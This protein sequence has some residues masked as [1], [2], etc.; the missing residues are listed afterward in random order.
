MGR[1]KKAAGLKHEATISPAL[2]LFVQQTVTVDVPDLP[3]HLLTFPRRWPFPRGDLYH[4]IVVLNRFD[5]I[6]QQVIEKY[7]LNSGPQTKPFGRLV[8]YDTC[9]SAGIALTPE[10]CQVHL[11]TRGFGPEGDRELIEALLDFSRLLLEKCG[12]RS[13]YSSSD[14]LNDLLNTTSLSLLQTALRLG[15]SLAQRYFSRQRQSNSTHFHQSL[16]ASHYNIELE[17]VQK[18]A[19]PFPKPA[20]SKPPDTSSSVKGKEKVAQTHTSRGDSVTKCNANDLI[21]LTKESSDTSEP[22]EFPAHD[23]EEWASIS[24]PY[25]SPSPD[26]NETTVTEGVGSG[27]HPPATPTPLRRVST[28]PSSRLSRS[29]VTDDSLTTPSTSS[30]TNRPEETNRGVKVLEIPS[31]TI[32]ST[33]IEQVLQAHL[34]ELPND[35]SKYELLQRLRVAYAIATSTTTRCQILAIRVLAVTN[36]AYVYP[37]TIFQQKVLYQDSDVPKRLQLAYQL[38]EFVHLGVAGDITAST[39]NQTFALNCLD[40]LA[41]HKTRSADVCAALTVNVNHGILMFL[42][43]KAVADLAVEEKPDDPPEADDWREALFA[44]LRTLPNAGTRTPETLVAAGLIPLFVDILNLRT[45]KA[46]KIY[47]RVMEFLDTFVHSVRDALATLAGAKG[48]HA[49]SD[50]I[51]FETKTSFDSVSKDRG[52]PAQ[53]KTPSIDYKIP[54]FQQ[55]SLR[56]LFKFV[57]HVMQH[58]S[59]GFERLLRNLIDSPP[60]LTALRLVLENA[61]VYGSHVWSGAVNILSHF[62]HNEPTSYAVIA[63][64]GLSRSLLEAVTAQ[65]MQPDTT[66]TTGATTEDGSINAPTEPQ[67]LFIPGR[68]EPGDHEALKSKITRPSGRKLAEGI[69][70]STEAI[71]CIPQAFGAI[72]L[73]QG[74]LELFRRSDALESFFDIFESPE[75]VK[76]MKNDSNL[77]RVLG[78]SFD[79][80]VRHHPA[81][82][83]AVMSSVLLMVARVVQHCKSK[84]WEHGLGAKLWTEEDDG[85]LSIAGGPSSLLGDIGSTFTYTLANQQSPS[86]AEPADTE[87]QS[88]TTTPQD[89]IVKAPP[90]P[91]NWDFKDLD[92]HGLSVPNYMF[93]VVRFLHAFFE[94][95]AICA[96]FIESGGVEYVLDFAT[97]QSLPFDF[98]NTEASQQLAQVIHLM[99]EVKPH[100]V[101]PSLMKRTEDAVD[102]LT[103]FWRQSSST[104]FFTSLT[105]PSKQLE[106]TETPESEDV[107]AKGTYFAKHLVAVHTLTDILREAYTPPIYPTRPSQQTSP[108]VQVNLADKYVALV[109][110]LGAL[111]SACVWEEILLQK[112][113]PE[114]WNEATRVPGYSFGGEEGTEQPS[115]LPADDVS[116][117]GDAAT[118]DAP[119]TTTAGTD[120]ARILPNGEASARNAVAQPF[121]TSEKGPAFRNVKTL[122]YLLSSL[123]SS[124][125]SFFHLLGHGLISKRRMDTYQR[126]KA[127]TVADAI[128]SMILEQINLDAPKKASCIKDQFSYLIVILSSFSQ[129][130]FDTTAERPHSHCLTMILSAFKRL[131]G[132]QALKDLCGL[133]LNEIKTLGPHD[134][135]NGNSRDVPARLASAYGGIKIILNF[136]SEMTSAQYIIDSPQTQAMASAGGDRDRPD[137]FLPAQFLVEFRMEVMPMAQEMWSSSFVEEASSSILK[138]LIDILRSV[139]GG[140]YETGA[141]RRGE[142]L[143]AV[144]AVTPKPFTCHRERLSTL[145]DNGHDENLAREALYRCNNSASASEEYCTSQHG[146]RPPPRNPVPS[147]DLEQATSN[148]T[149]LRDSIFAHLGSSQQPPDNPQVLSATPA[150]IASLLGHLAQPTTSTEDSGTNRPESTTPS[151]QGTQSDDPSNTSGLLAMSIDNILNDQEESPNEERNTLAPAAEGSARPPP[152]SQPAP[153]PKRREVVTVEDLDSERDKIR[154]NLIERCLDVLNV[155][156]DITFELADLIGS[157]TSKLPD[158][159]NFRREMEENFQS[160]G[161]KIAA[162][163]GLLALVLQDK[164]VYDATLEELKENFSNL[165]GF[166]KIPS[167]SSEKPTEESCPWIPQV[168]LILERVLSDDVT[169]SLIRW[170]PPSPD[171]SVGPEEVAELNQPIVPLSDKMALF[172]AMVDILPRVGKDETL[173]LSVSR[174][175]VI[176][177]RERDIAVRLGERRNLQRLFVMIK[178]LASGSDDR[179]QN[180]F[181][182]ILRHIIEDED[183]VRQIMRSEIV[184]GFESRSPRQTDTTGYV[185]QFAHLILRNPTLFV[186]VTNEK[187]KLQRYDSH[188]RPQLLVL[189]SEANNADS[190]RDQSSS[191]HEDNETVDRPEATE[192]NTPPQEGQLTEGKEG[193]DSKEKNKT[194]ELKPPIVE[195]PDGVIHYLLSELLSYR[196]VDDKEPP[197]DSSEKSTTHTESQG[198]VEMLSGPASPTSSTSGTQTTKSP[199]KTDKPQFKADEH[200]IYIYRCFLLQCLTELLS[201]YNRTKVEF[202]NFSRKADPFATTPSKPRSG[203]LNYLLN[204]LVPIGT[205]E[206]GESIFFKKRVNTSNWAMR[207]IVALCSKTGEFG[208]PFRRRTVP[209]DDD[210]PDLLFVRKFVLEHALKSY[211]DANASNEPLDAKYARLLSLADLFDKMLS[212][213]SSADGTTHFPS[214]TRQVAKTMF[215]KNFISAFTASI[216]ELDLNFPPAKRAVKYILRPLNKLTQT[217]VLL[218]ETSSIQ[219]APGQTDEDD[220]SSATSVSD[221]DDER[222]ETPDLFRHSTLGMFEPNHE[223]G[224]TSEEDSEDDEEMYDDEYDEEMDYEEDMPENDGEVVSDEDEE[225]MDGR[226]P[227]EGL[228]GDSGMDIEVL[229]EGDDDEDDDD[230]DEDDDDDDDEDDEDEEGSSAMDDDLIAGEITGD[231]DNDSLQDGDEGEWESEDLSDN[232]E[233][234][235][236]MNQLENELDDFAQ[237]D[238]GSNLQNVLRILGEQNGT[239]LDIQ[240]LELEMGVG[241]ELHDHLMNDEM[242]DDQDE[243]EEVDELEGLDD[244]DEDEDLI[245]TF[246]FEHPDRFMLH[247]TDASMDHNRHQHHGRFRGIPPPPWSMFSGG[248]GSRHGIIPIPGYRTHRNQIQ[249]RGNDDG[250][251]PLLRRNDRPTDVSP[252][253][254]GPPEALSDWVHAID[255]SH[256]GRLL[257]MDSPVTFMNAIMQAL[258]QGGG[259]IGVVSRPDGVHVRLDQGHVFTNRI[260]DLF[261]LSR[262]PA[263]T[264][265]PRDDPYQAVTFVLSTTSTRW[266]E[267]AR[268]LFNDTYLEK[269]QRVVNSLLKVL[270]PPAIE[271]EKVRQKQL[272][273]E[274]RR[275]E[276]ER[277]ERERLE[278]IAKEEAERERKQKEEEE[279]ALRLQQEAE[280]AE[281]AAEESALQAAAQPEGEPMDDVQPTQPS[282]PTQEQ[283]AIPAEPEP[284]TTGPSEPTPRI[285]T[286]I[287][288]RQLDITGMD[289]DPEYLEALPEDIREE[290]IMQQLTEQRSQAAASGEEPSEINPEFL[291]ALPP[292]IR[293]ELLQQEV[294]DRRR[295]ERETA[296]RNAAANGGTAAP[297]DMDPA[298]FIATLDPSL[299]QTVLA[300][301]PEEILASLGPEFVSE[302]RALTGRRLAQFAD[303]GRLDPR[304]RPDTAQ[305]DQGVKKPQRRQ[306]VQ[307]LDKAGVATLLRLMFM[308]LQGN[309]RHHINDILHNVCQNRQ[310]RSEVLSLL[311]L[312][313]QDGSADVSAVER[314][315]AHL[316]LRAKTPAAT[317]R[318]PQVKRTL[319]LPVPGANNDVTPLVVIQQ[320]LG[321]LSF[322]TRFNPHIAW[323]FLTEHDT[324]SSLKIKALRKGKAKEHRAS[325]FALNSLLSLLDRKSIMDS[326]NCMEQLSS[327]LSNITQPLTLLLR[328]DKE[329]QEKEA[330]DKQAEGTEPAAESTRPAQSVEAASEQAEGTRT[331]DEASP[332]TDMTMPDAA[333][334]DQDQGRTEGQDEAA[335]SST[336]EKPESSKPVEEEKQKKLRIPEPPVVPEHNLQLVVRI[337]AARECNG[338]TFRDTLSTINNLSAIP[339]AREVFGK[340]LIAQTQALSNAILIDLDELLPHIKQAETGIDVQGM[341]LSKFSPASS[342]QAKLLRALT[343]LDYLFDPNRLDKEKYSEPESSNKDN[344]LKALYEGATFGPLW[345]KLS[346][347]LHAIRQKENMLNVATILLPLIESLMVVCKNTTLK[348]APLSRHGRE[349]SVSSPPPESGMEGLFFNFTEDHRKI[350]NELVRQN[351]KLM[352][353]TFSLLVKNPKV[354]EFDNKRNYFTRRIHSRGSEI[355]HP[356][357]PLQL[358]VRRDQ[359]FLD[360]F[361]SLYFKTANEMKYGKLNIRFHGE[362]GVDAGGVTREWFQ[363]LARGMFN[364][365]YALFIPVASDRTTFH[366]NRLSGVNQE[367]LMFFKFIGR[368]IGKALYEGRVLDC[369]FSRAVY[370]RILGKAVS[371]KD[372]ETLDLDYYKSLLWMLE[373]DITDILTENFSV[374]SDD[375]G[376]K[377]IIDL[378]E[379]GRNIPVTQENKEEYVQRVVEYRLVGSVKDQLDNFLKGFHD[380]IPADLISIF[381]EQELELLISG[382]PEIDVD[383]WKNNSEY[384]NYSASSPQIQWFWRAVRS[385]DKEER[386]KLLQFVTGTSKVPLN[387][388]KELEGMNG[389]SKFNIHRDYGNKDRLPSSHTCFNQLDLPEYESYETLR[390]RLYTAM[391]AG[392]EYFGFA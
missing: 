341:A 287:R 387:G 254:R 174:I 26:S 187:I 62:I 215:E 179:L 34:G 182:V 338:K 389:F 237:G 18:L 69:I 356:H 226:G 68:A 299:R 159:V 214:S 322:L 353:G 150:D 64:A 108:F 218:S 312:I 355:R 39:L 297:D 383:D 203:I 361:K 210:E 359:V 161:K 366:P 354:L 88:A 177:T 305:R 6:L 123:P 251:N 277:V 35:A 96:S 191:S 369:H 209:N 242:Q 38:A 59:G 97:L 331:A 351:P 323:F 166:I 357:P 43:R 252:G 340:E 168:L 257:S 211:K 8:L 89:G 197:T 362:E 77:V 216:S 66:D 318:T 47:P 391:T 324:A 330:K 208:G 269:A 13:L 279:E 309:A 284:A 233:E 315:F 147:H 265:R 190:R 328:K 308:P 198:D 90:K 380:I 180:T 285:H 112:D 225:D 121:V 219:S 333:P 9:I 334:T 46:R 157:A 223:E 213:G 278:Q 111:H 103:P 91:E 138:S 283:A 165:L 303:V 17:R 109:K 296:R 2:A 275:R 167:V 288:G 289:I 139:L 37:E 207:V 250:V 317:Q 260:Q 291:E 360:S 63:E 20:L 48:F 132:I 94:N 106:N 149:S 87:M 327:L 390:Q 33:K 176:L 375:F 339:G 379:N 3:S 102:C 178:Q 131:N 232:D 175:L 224:T 349:Y 234:E 286:T 373:N 148:S 83:S 130:L 162:Y 145:K 363:V 268:L 164:D 222:E 195:N 282:E 12:N 271:E 127:S 304:S 58:N 302:A 204:S 126:Q 170:S 384:H 140:E 57:N 262:Q 36:L 49:I 294:A 31:E 74:G 136:F 326:P 378:V 247:D 65:T 385:F 11:D 371:I 171:G 124:I 120:P 346:E 348:D 81:L 388:F 343:A 156:H 316:S 52:I 85:A 347:S 56:W 61:R 118:E 76:C 194:A 30:P 70:P 193:K 350:L 392:S 14:R 60:L 274:L 44:L 364:P 23:W 183:T 29:S 5:E 93:P 329:K 266:Q 325:K 129:L 53:F 301:Q 192:S 21:A 311:L 290:V 221:V 239:H 258:G 67:H 151:N 230:D 372:M 19:A 51:S 295:R 310:N 79:E 377:Q 1:I 229:I 217:A 253:S 272:E 306:I 376:E 10:E 244:V 298:S 238:H 220:I 116:E 32:V 144:S 276:E 152:A 337:L 300:D 256:Q 293:D 374:E 196:D 143:P 259:G 172:D 24:M 158:P 202:I 240:R 75:H 345:A 110:R 255:P 114:S 45:E 270:V 227:I 313:L 115:T 336:E 199:K 370:K 71:V 235:D 206:H 263:I 55:Q 246:D 314:S 228:P 367:H 133:F 25:Y 4:W 104:G 186:E 200:P 105:N 184:A 137:Y 320:C 205:L 273:E 72:C 16:L 128:A 119:G 189:K 358:S 98:H 280:R 368:I 15:V 73:N 267:E 185:R 307:M 261:G 80:L 78:N 92:S 335:G 236:G 243:D 321:A 135:E 125:T 241:G 101:L 99:A 122:R 212:G 160:A 332:Q 86:G 245:Q 22:N 381:N 169:P 231:N 153:S 201:S 113:M 95:H 146:L 117:P 7:D 107:K 142:T 82:K 163:A 42:T 292:D 54:Y 264:T 386:A 134:E 188:Q 365:N 28:H 319:S 382:L 248:L 344:I 154:S 342:D 50:L 41:K 100:L 84:A 173:A 249:P 181:M 155:H 141:F 281:R 40:A 352:S 27:P